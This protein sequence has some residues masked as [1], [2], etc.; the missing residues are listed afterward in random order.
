MLMFEKL[1]IFFISHTLLLERQNI[2]QPVGEI[3]AHKIK[4]KFYRDLKYRYIFE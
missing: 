3:Q 1:H 4:D 2:L